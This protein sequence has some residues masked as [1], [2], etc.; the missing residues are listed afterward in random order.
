MKLLKRTQFG[1]PI[2]RETARTLTVA[3]A[4]SDEIQE[5]ITNMFHTVAHKELGV[6]LAAPQVGRGVSLTVITVQPTAHRPKVTPFEVVLI[7]P[8]ITETHGRRV[9]LWEGCISGGSNGK[10]DLFA[11]VPRFKKVTV[12]YLDEKGTK[13]TKTF[14]GLQAQIVQHEV[15]HLNG[16]LFVDRVTDTSTYCT[17]NEYIKR[18]RKGDR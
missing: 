4:K 2:L 16:I 7:N 3:E 15:D 8:K 6:G 10:A 9:Q 17:Y 11:K 5:L 14:E 13:H 18:H 1:H 12:N